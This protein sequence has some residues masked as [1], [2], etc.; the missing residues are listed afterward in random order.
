[1]LRTNFSSGFQPVDANDLGFKG[2]LLRGR[3]PSNAEEKT[4]TIL[5]LNTVH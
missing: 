2:R 5:R 1:V 4:K 3:G